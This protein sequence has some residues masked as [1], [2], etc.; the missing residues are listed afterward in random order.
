MK[1]FSYCLYGADPKYLQGMCINAEIIRNKFPDWLV[2]I[3]YRDLPAA[4]L[5][6]LSKYSHV[7]MI[8]ASYLGANIMF[9]RFTAIDDPAVSIMIVRDADSRVHERDCWAIN[10]FIKSGLK[11]HIIRDH[12]HHKFHML[13]GLWG[14]KQGVLKFKIRDSFASYEIAN[15]QPKWGRDQ[16]YLKDIIYPLIK[17]NVLIH[18]SMKVGAEEN[19]VPF[20]GEVKD[21]GFCGQIVFFDSGLEKQLYS[22]GL[23]NGVFAVDWTKDDII[24]TDKYLG[25][26]T[27]LSGE[28]AYIKTDVLHDNRSMIWRGQPHSG[29]AA[30]VWITGHSTYPITDKLFSQFQENNSA[31]FC[32]NKECNN[33]KLVGIPLGITN[34]CDDTPIHRIFGNIDVMLDICKTDKKDVNLAYINFTIDNCAAERLEC[35]NMFKDKNWVSMGIEDRSIAGRKLFLEEVRNHTFVFCPRGVGYDTHRLWETLYMGSIPIVKRCLALAGFSDLPILFVDDWSEINERFLIRKY[36]EFCLKKPKWDLTKLKV[37]YWINMIKT[38][39]TEA[40]AAPP[41][42][43]SGT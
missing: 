21:G 34:D 40:L 9:D 29:R 38:A 20:P 4:Y 42:E 25:L 5:S 1:V 28:I 35:Y 15:K 30:K 3:Y 32:L 7:R 6:K 43:I 16:E 17:N 31:W 8:P 19:L 2:Y 12:P 23:R 22:Y 13:G 33:S 24:C 37:G 41:V 11:A 18:G 39:A 26:D 36:E 27:G 14:L 10:E